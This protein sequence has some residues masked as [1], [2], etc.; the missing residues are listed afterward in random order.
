MIRFCMNERQWNR[1][2]QTSQLTSLAW[3]IQIGEG[4]KAEN[5]VLGEDFTE[6]EDM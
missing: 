1:I 3:R 6:V 5:K 4:F 2:C